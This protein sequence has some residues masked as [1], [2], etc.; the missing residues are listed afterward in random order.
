M[1]YEP[2]KRN[3]GLEHDPFKACV[4]PRPIGWISTLSTSGVAN[5]APYSFFNAVSAVPPMVMFSSNGLGPDGPKD[6][7]TNCEQSG[8]F[9]VNIATWDLRDQI[10]QTSFA[11]ASE[12]DEMEQVGLAAAECRVVA[13]PRVHHCPIALECKYWKTI[14][15]PGLNGPSSNAMIL[16]E[17]VGVHID[18][19]IFVNGRIDIAKL[20]PIAR[21]GYMDY[22]V[23]ESTF[24]MPRPSK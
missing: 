4:V 6:S 23:V 18:D 11:Y 17:V 12:V 21:L 5:L 8:E 13:A 1:F 2:R 24:T 16:G 14:E 9:V 10:N 3:H 7:R 20:K 19:E 15:L 22:A